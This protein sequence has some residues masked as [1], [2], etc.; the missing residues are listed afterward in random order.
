MQKRSGLERAL[1]VWILCFVGLAFWSVHVVK[2]QERTVS[3][4]SQPTFIQ[5]SGLSS[6]RQQLNTTSFASG[7]LSAWPVDTR[8]SKK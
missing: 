8:F 4:A 7:H 2:S 5:G 3:I 6:A 1:M